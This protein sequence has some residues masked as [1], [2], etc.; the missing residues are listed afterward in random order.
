M[1][2]LKRGYLFGIVAYGLWGF[3]PLYIRLLLPAGAM[4][5]LAHRVVWAVAFVALLLTVVRR[6]PF[7][8]ELAR[9]PGTLAGISLASALIAVNWG[10]YIFGINSERV[11]ETA[12]GYFIGPL[13]MVLLGV[14][15]LRE[16]LN[17]TQWTAVGIGTLA[18][19]VLTVD[20]GR[21]PFIALTLAVSFGAYSLVKKRLGL[22]A[23][24]GLF[25]ESAVLALPALAYLG[26]LTARGDSTF[27]SGAGHTALLVVAG[28]ATATPLLLFAGAANRIPMTGIGILQYIAP[29]LQLG[30]GVLIFHEPMP[31]ARLAGFALVWLALVV[32]TI[33]G[34]RTGRR[35][36]ADRDREPVLT[37]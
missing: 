4:E 27:G 8:R 25:V 15:A 6:W 11:V 33:D 30:C 10:M 23:A 5:I 28:A 36:A 7:L 34:L 14:V 29:I 1:S 20:Y 2:E 19:A 22:P 12:L 31:P 16:R 9:H 18:V 35:R 24:E 21:P 26:W 32:F 37:A 13:V 3:F 17:P